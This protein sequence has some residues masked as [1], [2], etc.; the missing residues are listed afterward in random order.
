MY[1]D[2]FRLRVI[3]NHLISNALRYSFPKQREPYVRINAEAT[4]QQLEVKVEDNG[5]G[6]SENHVSRIFDM[7]YRADN[8][9]AGSGLGIYIVKETVEN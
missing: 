9:K 4:S 6:I 8:C 3:F 2:P 5:Q 1:T 7:F